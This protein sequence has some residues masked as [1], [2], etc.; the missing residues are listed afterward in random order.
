[1]RVLFVTI[2]LVLL[3]GCLAPMDTRES[4]PAY[5]PTVHKCENVGEDISRAMWLDRPTGYS[6]F[7][8]TRFFMVNKGEWGVETLPSGVQYKVLREGCG[9]IPSPNSRVTVRYH[10]TLLDGRVFDSSYE[11]GDTATFPLNQV[12]P[13]WTQAV[14]NMQPGDIWQVFI[15]GHLAYGPQSPNAS[16]P[17]NAALIFTIELISF[18]Q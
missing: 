4:R 7:D 10:G 9:D 17:P 5:T 18:I 16:I 6:A 13:G 3:S 14:T 12:I 1:M 8:A 2:F 15:P 11:R